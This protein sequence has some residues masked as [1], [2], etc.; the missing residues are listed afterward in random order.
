MKKND[1]KKI[2]NAKQRKRVSKRN[3]ILANAAVTGLLLTGT[4]VAPATL[5]WA[6]ST[7]EAA[8]VDASILQN[9]TTSNDSGTI[10]NGLYDNGT[11]YRVGTGVEN[12]NIFVSG[13]SPIDASLISDNNKRIV[14]SI[15]EGVQ[16]SIAT[17]GQ[18]QINS[19]F[20]LDLNNVPLLSGGLSALTTAVGGL[21]TGVG[22]IVDTITGTAGIISNVSTTGVV[23][24]ELLDDLIALDTATFASDV[25][26]SP[27]GTH[28]YVDVNDGLGLILAQ[29]VTDI[30]NDLNAAIND[31][32][33]SVDPNASLPIRLAATPVVAAANLILN[34]I[35]TTLN[36]AVNLL[37]NPVINN[38]GE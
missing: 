2:M 36:A 11:A 18:A 32:S 19:S 30:L 37:L 24:Q 33:I 10:L 29:N 20:S 17:N 13:T 3:S 6:P 8:L 1:Y 26:L 34:P 23:I 12:F 7:V 15:P 22:Q 14:I 16:G 35:K 38:A 31:L 25:T 27:D 21:V 9:V 4:V 5:L 28:L